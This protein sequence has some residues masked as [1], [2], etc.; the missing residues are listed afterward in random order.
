M[1]YFV[2]QNKK[3]LDKDACVE[4]MHVKPKNYQQTSEP[5]PLKKKTITN[6]SFMQL[7]PYKCIESPVHGH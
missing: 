5:N 4:S 2:Q 6:Y 1:Y 7:H 3:K